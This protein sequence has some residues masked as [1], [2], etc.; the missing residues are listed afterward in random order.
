M[1][2]GSGIMATFRGNGVPGR[3]PEGGFWDAGNDPG[4]AYTSMFSL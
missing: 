2:L 1:L 3:G 4:S